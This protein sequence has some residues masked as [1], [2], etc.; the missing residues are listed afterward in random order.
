MFYLVMFLSMIIGMFIYM[1]DPVPPDMRY[2]LTARDTEGQIVTFLNQHQAAKNY[3]RLSLARISVRNSLNDHQIYTCTGNF[4]DD[5]S[6]HVEKICASALPPRWAA[7]LVGNTTDL[8]GET[9]DTDA[10]KKS[11]RYYTKTYLSDPH[12]KTLEGEFISALICINGKTGQLAPCYKG[13]PNGKCRDPY[14]ILSPSSYAMQPYSDNTAYFVVTYSMTNEL[15]ESW[16]AF[17]KKALATRSHRS[18]QC[19]ILRKGKFCFNKDVLHGE[20]RVHGKACPSS[21][22]SEYSIDNGYATLS[23]PPPAVISFVK[24]ALKTDNLSD[25]LLCFSH[26]ENPYI[27]IEAPTV[28]YDGLDLF[29]IGT[30]GEPESTGVGQCPIYGSGPA[31]KARAADSLRNTAIPIPAGDHTVN[32]VFSAPTSASSSSYLNTSGG[33]STYAITSTGKDSKGWEFEYNFQGQGLHK[34]EAQYTPGP[35]GA[36]Q[37]FP[38]VFTIV[39][40]SNEL[41]F[42][43][44]GCQLKE[45]DIP[46]AVSGGTFTFGPV[47]NGIQHAVLQDFRLYGTALTGSQIKRNFK[48]D[49]FRY[50]AKQ[51]ACDP[52]FGF[53]GAWPL[54]PIDN[55]F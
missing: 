41:Y 33:S 26:I 47:Q 22:K 36:N 7:M 6:S 16:D 4:E 21:N 2:D 5:G 27:H 39:Q 29:A 28:H 15:P 19:G 43:Y 34:V 53:I 24:K 23:V 25:Y 12:D 55:N 17:G 54:K 8:F 35:E 3:A 51:A 20:Q 50:G 18:T 40:R 14:N 30:G 42:F 32:L 48:I 1:M 31:W 9:D 45:K 46:R 37:T 44:N 10:T 13:L 49:E 38:Q 11:W 52:P